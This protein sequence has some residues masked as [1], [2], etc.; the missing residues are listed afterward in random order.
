[1]AMTIIS[2]IKSSHTDVRM[3]HPGEVV[4]YDSQDLT[5]LDVDDLDVP[6]LIL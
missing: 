2:Q 4:N 3:R 1:M 6:S 5:N